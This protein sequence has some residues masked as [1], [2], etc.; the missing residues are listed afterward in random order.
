LLLDRKRI[1]KWAKWVALFLAVV[2]VL[3]FLLLGVGYGGGAGFNLFELFGNDDPSNTTLTPDQKVAA[4]LETLKQNPSDVTTLLAL[5]TIYQ[6]NGDPKTAATWLEQA[7]AVDPNQKDVYLRLANIYMSQEVADYTAAA[8]V[9]NKAVSRYP[10]D[11]DFYLKLGI[12]QN[13]IGNSEAALLAW[14]KYLTLAPDGDMASVI[15]EQ[16]D[17]MSQAATTTT[18][19]AGTTATTAAGSTS[20]TAGSS[21]PTTT[22]TTATQP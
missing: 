12:A 17:K 14:Q 3:S 18:S 5:A 21:T 7:I 11:A 10:D 15:R 9:L 13:N 8:A 22:P 4:L 1:R 2:F 20:T 16:V 19:T 6:Q